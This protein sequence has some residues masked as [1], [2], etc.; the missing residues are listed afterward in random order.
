MSSS[1]E[2]EPKLPL[3]FPDRLGTRKPPGIV[4]IHDI[5]GANDFYKDLAGRL[6]DEGY[7]AVLPDLFVRQGELQNHSR[8][9]RGPGQ[10]ARYRPDP[11]R[12]RGNCRH[13]RDLKG[14]EG[15]VGVIGFC[16]GGTLAMLSAS[17]SAGRMRLVSFYGFPPARGPGQ[18]SRSM[19]SASVRAPLLLIVGDQDSGVGMENMAEVRSRAR[20]R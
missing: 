11:G 6:A 4:I 7:L 3:Q 14:A 12:H 2:T 10:R 16:M 1:T 13:V 17:W 18:R 19:T 20:R 5:H 9:A 15:P 8:E